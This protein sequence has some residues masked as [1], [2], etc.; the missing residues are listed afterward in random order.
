MNDMNDINEY[1]NNLN[2]KNIKL[3]ICGIHLPL[4]IDPSDE[5]LLIQAAKL[6]DIRINER[7]KNTQVV[8]PLDITAIMVALSTASELLQAQNTISKGIQNQLE[9]HLQSIKQDLLIMNQK[10]D[11]VMHQLNIG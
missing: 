8:K 2:R 1:S 5:E 4:V 6:I 10:A 9:P 3:N 7:R 11:V